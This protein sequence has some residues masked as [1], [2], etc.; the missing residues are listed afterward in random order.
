[1]LTTL[2]RF[3]PALVAF[4]VA[5]INATA[6]DISRFVAEHPDVA[7]NG[8][9]LLTTIANAISPKKAGIVISDPPANQQ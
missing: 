9:A 4:I 8:Y 3:L 5:M 7:V 6:P 2:A 1:M